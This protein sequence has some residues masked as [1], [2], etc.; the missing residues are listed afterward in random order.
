M[1]HFDSNFFKPLEPLVRSSGVKEWL[2]PIGWE[3][4]CPSFASSVSPKRQ[5]E[6]PNT[7]RWRR[8]DQ[9]S[10]NMVFYF[11][12]I[13]FMFV[14]EKHARSATLHNKPNPSISPW[15][16]ISHSVSSLSLSLCPHFIANSWGRPLFS[17]GRCVSCCAHAFKRVLH[18]RYYWIRYIL[19]WEKTFKN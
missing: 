16:T 14:K 10:A 15:L 3:C 7:V 19:Y 12:P 8:D 6:P 17:P 5:N 11:A 4:S 9:V 13:D 1:Y 2:K 18:S